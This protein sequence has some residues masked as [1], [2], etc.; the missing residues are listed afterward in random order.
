ME[1]EI[2]Y[3]ACA[4]PPPLFKSKAWGPPSP[5]LVAGDSF[6]VSRP[7]PFSFFSND[8]PEMR[9]GVE[10]GVGFWRGVN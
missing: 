4:S 6:S 8:S 2:M 3:L 5:G 9:S 1:F 7:P 10:R